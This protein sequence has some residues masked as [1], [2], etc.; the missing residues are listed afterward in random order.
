M[1]TLCEND[2]ALLCMD[3]VIFVFAFFSPG[4]FL[5]ASRSP[6]VSHCGNLKLNLL[7]QIEF[8]FG[9]VKNI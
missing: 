6:V 4:R 5:T 2:L 7:N 9:K 3:D 8:N 1:M